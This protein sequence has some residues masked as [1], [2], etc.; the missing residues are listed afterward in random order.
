MRKQPAAAP[1]SVLDV[2]VFFPVCTP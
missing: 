2:S 1:P